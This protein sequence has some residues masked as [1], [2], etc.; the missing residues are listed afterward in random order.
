MGCIN[1][2]RSIN[3]NSNN[4]QQTSL[5]LLHCP[6]SADLFRPLRNAP[7]QS[8]APEL[9][10]DSTGRVTGLPPYRWSTPAASSPSATPSR[11]CATWATSSTE[12]ASCRKS[13]NIFRYTGLNGVSCVRRASFH[14]RS[15][16]SHTPALTYVEEKCPD[17]VELEAA[18]NVSPTTDRRAE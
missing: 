15:G 14:P 6:S 2:N 11:E 13:R 1:N 17:S 18:L 9:G 16:E 4:N 12:A 8:A 10:N 3:N 5:S 7:V